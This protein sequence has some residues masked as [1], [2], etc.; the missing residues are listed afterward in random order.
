MYIQVEEKKNKIFLTELN[1]DYKLEF[2]VDKYQPELCVLTQDESSPYKDLIS[3]H[4]LQ[5]IKFDS[6]KDFKEYKHSYKSVGND[7]LYGDVNPEYQ[8][9]REKYKGQTA[10]K[11]RFWYLDIETAIPKSGF[12][13]P[14]TTPSAITLIQIAENDN[15]TAVILAYLRVFR[16]KPNVRYFYCK[17]E[18]EMLRL[19]IKYMHLRTPSITTAWNGDIFDF[20][21]L[22]NR[23]ENLGMDIKEVSPFGEFTEHRVVAF[24][25]DMEIR[26]PVGFVWI[27]TIEAYKKADP[28]G[29]ESFSLEYMSKYVL[30][31]DE[32]GKLDYTKSGFKNMRDFLE[33]RYT[34]S[35]DKLGTLKDHYG[36]DSFEQEHYN[37]FVEYGI[38]DVRIL[39]KM[40]TKLGLMNMLVNMAHSM[41][42]NIYDIFATI[43]P[44]TVLLWNELYERDRFL[45]AK[46]PFETFHTDGGHVM[47]LPGL[48]KWVL[49][50]DYTSLYPFCMISL[51]LSPETYVPWENVPDELKELV[52]SFRRYSNPDEYKFAEDIYDALPEEHKNKITELLIKYNLVMAPNGSF[53]TREFQGIVPELVQRF[54]NER[55]YFKGL[56]KDAKKKKEEA[57]SKGEDYSRFEEIINVN[58]TNQYTKKIKINSKYGFIAA[59]TSNIANSDISN[60]ITSYGRYNIKKTTEYICQEVNKMHKD[61][62]IREVQMDTDSCYL[63]MESVVNVYKERNPEATR[64]DIV[65]FLENFMSKVITPLIQKSSTNIA[66]RF[67]AYE[68]SLAM[69]AEII[70]DTFVSVAKKRYAARIWWDEGTTLAEPK[71]KVTGLDIKRSDCPSDTRKK[72]ETVLDLIFDEKESGLINMISK[73][74]KEMKDLPIDQIAIP[75]GIK[76]ITKYEKNP[77]RIP[78]HVRASMV[79]NNF[80]KDNGLDGKYLKVHNGDKIK[81]IFLKK[82]P[83]TKSDIIAFKDL[84]F[85][86]ETGLDKYVD[87]DRLYERVFMSPVKK[88]TDAIKWETKKSGVVNKLF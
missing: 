18:E 59:T 3:G 48:Y 85:M 50:E 80:I 72:L 82:N 84:E 66:K 14:E 39:K 22:I 30:G 24:G 21:Y 26:K 61:F 35:L 83:I 27:D 2:K 5:K 88:L 25:K 41:G 45:P 86:E 52:K 11:S 73:Y 19:F 38:E 1:E 55:N 17:D 15:D 63:T 79:Y 49:S 78:M 40:D 70:A 58:D 31:E 42:S 36:K 65:K 34:P 64:E 57:K 44:W 16:E 37:I 71:K 7:V 46:T 10:P 75:T 81:Y 33:G 74:K 4:P 8:Y 68:D 69:D 43:K 6:I 76:D 62:N 20:P 23:M 56:M 47:A 67:N 32:G 13:D 77:S 87:I 51:N 28:S 54:Y 29:K 53:Y 60:A 9:I 12:P